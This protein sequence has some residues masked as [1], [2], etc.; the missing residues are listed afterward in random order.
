[1]KKKG[2]DTGF[3]IRVWRAQVTICLRF[4]LLNRQTR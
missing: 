3:T 4:R 2:A 1:M